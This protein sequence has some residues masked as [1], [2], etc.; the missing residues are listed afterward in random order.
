VAPSL[1]V[2]PSTAARAV[3]TWARPDSARGDWQA[4]PGAGPPAGRTPRA[5]RPGAVRRGERRAGTE[6]GPP[7]SKARRAAPA[8]P[9]EAEMRQAPSVAPRP[10][11]GSRCAAP[12]R[13]FEPAAVGAPWS[14]ALLLEAPRFAA[15]AEMPWW[16]VTGT[17][18]GAARSFAAAMALLPPTTGASEI[19]GLLAVS[20]FGR[21]EASGE[22][23]AMTVRPARPPAVS[24]FAPP[25][26]PGEHPLMTMLPARRSA[27]SPFA[28]ETPVTEARQAPTQSL[29]ASPHADP[30]AAT[31]HHRAGRPQA[32]CRP[33]G[34][35]A[36]AA[37]SAAR[38]A[39]S[40]RS[41]GAQ[42]RFVRR[43]AGPER[44]CSRAA[45]APRRGEAPARALPSVRFSAHH[46]EPIRARR[47]AA[48]W[49]PRSA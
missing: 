15:S 4:R 22:Q 27:G 12:A 18:P 44:V 45:E 39:E 21:P 8:P 36:T 1:P 11:A 6:P 16:P 9:P 7:H 13:S 32:A 20:Q 19:Q 43:A 25:G 47:G 46:R 23:P 29:A 28:P 31:P 41:P 35:H 42:P 10:R 2:A 33:H 38:G 37:S 26:A 3:A 48:E 40:A 14:R 5:A 30:R 17:P 49:P 34:S 24:P